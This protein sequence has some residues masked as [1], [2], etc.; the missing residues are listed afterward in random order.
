MLLK[1]RSNL[2]VFRNLFDSNQLGMKKLTSMAGLK[3]MRTLSVITET[4]SMLENI[5]LASFCMLFIFEGVVNVKH[6]VVCFAFL[7]TSKAD[8][9]LLAS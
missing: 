5:Y 8:D 4:A 7:W 3:T 9:P 2:A 6:V 1:L